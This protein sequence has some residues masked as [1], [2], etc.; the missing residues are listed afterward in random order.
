MKG[1]G[2]F[3]RQPGA[4]GF[5]QCIIVWLF[6][7]QDVDPRAR[8]PADP[9]GAEAA[10]QL[11]PQVAVSAL[12][13]RQQQEARRIKWCIFF[14]HSSRGCQSSGRLPVTQRRTLGWP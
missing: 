2:T 1:K 8:P 11:L 14:A 7:G 5:R 10:G 6:A 9:I 12:G 4:S 3:F 13:Q